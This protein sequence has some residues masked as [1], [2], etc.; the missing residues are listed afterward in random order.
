MQQ[1]LDLPSCFPEELAPR[2]LEVYAFLRTFG[3]LLHLSPFKVSIHKFLELCSFLI[4]SSESII[5]WLIWGPLLSD[6]PCWIYLDLLD[7]QS[8]SH[9]CLS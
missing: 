5:T 9:S 4:L 2:A 8:I 3:R 7:P 6:V 1:V